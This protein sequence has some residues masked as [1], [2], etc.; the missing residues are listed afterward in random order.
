MKGRYPKMKTSVTR[1]YA[2][3]C[4]VPACSII[5][6]VDEIICSR[7][8]NQIPSYPAARGW[9]MTTFHMIAWIMIKES[10][11]WQLCSSRNSSLGSRCLEPWRRAGTSVPGIPRT[12]AL[13]RVG[14]APNY[15]LRLRFERNVNC[16][17]LHPLGRRA[18]NKSVPLSSQEENNTVEMVY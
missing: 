3:G 17:V 5:A 8:R 6:R 12:A 2:W 7:S 9:W 15:S 11:K 4:A 1:G 16:K 14:A 18:R 10:Q 13:S